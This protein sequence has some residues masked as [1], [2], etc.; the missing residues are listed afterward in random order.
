VSTP[1]IDA[2][3]AIAKQAVANLKKRE[4]GVKFKEP[5]SKTGKGKAASAQA[6]PTSTSI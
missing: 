3:T 2:M 1:K 6:T 5:R 4:V